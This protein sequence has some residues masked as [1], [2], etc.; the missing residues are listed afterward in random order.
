MAPEVIRRAWR[1]RPFQPFNLHLA[2]GRQLRVPSPEFLIVPD[3]GRIVIVHQPSGGRH[4][5]DLLLVTDLE[6]AD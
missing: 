3:E 5:V 4:L 1:L 2:D 6:F